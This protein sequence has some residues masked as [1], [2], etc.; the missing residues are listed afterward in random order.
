[1][2]NAAHLSRKSLPSGFEI[3]AGVVSPS[4]RQEEGLFEQAGGYGAKAGCLSQRSQERLRIAREEAPSEPNGRAPD[5]KMLAAKFPK[6]AKRARSGR[7]AA[8]HPPVRRVKQR[9]GAH[10]QRLAAEGI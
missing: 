2:A 1:M 5:A 8:A 6:C 3:R 9:P 4:P 10:G 7:M